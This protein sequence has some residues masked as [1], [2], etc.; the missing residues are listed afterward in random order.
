[1]PNALIPLGDLMF[2]PLASEFRIN[3]QKLDRSVASG[4]DRA[5]QGP[6]REEKEG[7]TAPDRDLGAA[8]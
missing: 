5:R 2:G 8:V 7:L 1:M 6:V 4:R 3:I